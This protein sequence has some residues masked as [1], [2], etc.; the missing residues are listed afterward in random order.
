MG[1]TYGYFGGA[2]RSGRCEIDKDTKDAEWST[3][4]TGFARF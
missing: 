3:Q 1:Y 2:W 4:R